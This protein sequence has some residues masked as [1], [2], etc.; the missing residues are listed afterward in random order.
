MQKQFK[1]IALYTTTQIPASEN[2]NLAVE[3]E[4]NGFRSLW[5]GESYHYRGAMATAAAIAS[6]TRRIKIGLGIVTP[7][8][9]H[10]ALIAMEAA[11]LDE[12]SGG[13]LILGLGVSKSAMRRH[14][15]D[16]ASQ[17][18]VQTI[19]ESAQIIR[20]LFSTRAT[21]FSG[22]IFEMTGSDR[23]LNFKPKRSR[24]PIYVGAIGPRMLQMAGEVADGAL[25]TS[26]T[27][28][29]YVRF[30]LGNV[31]EGLCRARR[32][33]SS[34]ELRSNLAFSV[35]DDYDD[36]VESARFIVA[37]Y[38]AT[39]A[40]T[41]PVILRYAGVKEDAIRDL[42]TLYR[43]RGMAAVV[44]EVPEE[45]V[46]K[47]VT[48]GTLGDCIRRL[49]RYRANGLQAVNLL[50]LSPDRARSIQLIRDGIVPELA[51]G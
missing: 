13:R 9:R 39:S 10:P 26:M 45:L 28:P 22:K 46:R 14:G 21:T 34:F 38:T 31:Q 16:S 7:Y 20:S 29:A 2:A 25:L 30:A 8:T 47:L 5:L 51:A 49:K 37:Y 19:R 17:S 32:S 6:R 50:D 4:H 24:I 23:K 48:C 42:Q 35:S 36:A 18:P 1:E 27:S 12:L 11:T 33:P 41:E 40:K 3:V 44:S 15:M 43:K